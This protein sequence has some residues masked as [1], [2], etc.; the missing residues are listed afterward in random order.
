MSLSSEDTYL[1]WS[2][3][4]FR[5]DPYP[6]YRRLQQEHPVYEL[7]G[8]YVVS[9]YEDIVRYLKLPIMSVETAWAGQ[10][11]WS[12][13]SDTMLGVDP[14]EHTA[15]R[16]HT[17]KWFTPKMVR[18]WA[19]TTAEVAGRALDR[20]GEDGF[21]EAWTELAAL[22]THA[23]MCRVLGLP[24]DDASAVVEAMFGAMRMMS[25]APKP[26]DEELA[27]QAFAYLEKRVR[28][29]LAD[30][31]SV[32]DNGMARALLA[33]CEAGELTTRESLATTTLF[34]GLGHMDVGYLVAAGLDQFARRPEV[35]QTYKRRPEVRAA[36]INEIVRLDPPELSVVR[37]PTE[38]VEIRGVR[39]PAGTPIRFMIA[40]ANRDP[41]IFPE[42]DAFDHMRSP[43]ES[44]N[45]SFGLGV[46]SC[47][48]QVISRAEAE[49]V[50]TEVARRFDRIEPAGE[51][52]RANNDF[53]RFYWSLPLRLC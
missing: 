15:R 11:P 9:R 31:A 50:F 46:H 5:T 12:Y 29:M 4:Q 16:R 27:A 48:G 24:D 39:I 25:A 17:N 51:P 10:G 33:A 8:T 20:V 34:Y 28:E 3:P 45:L 38:D 32:D 1:P 42:P 26:G 14:P 18:E 47:A 35:F 44:R 13:V 22:P 21:I 43:D 49:A 41:D 30:A 37:Y 53:A 40:A 2:D 36:I 23:T 7:D 52:V 19:R 6:W